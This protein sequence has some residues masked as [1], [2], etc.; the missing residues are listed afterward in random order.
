MGTVRFG[1]GIYTCESL[2]TVLE[3]ARLAESLGYDSLWLLDSQ[4]V[5]RECYATMASCALHTSR[6]TIGSGVTN[7]YTRHV[8]VTASAHLTLN[9]LA[10]G[11]IAVGIGRGDSAVLGLGAGVPSFGSY[12]EYVHAL[13]RLL[14]GEQIDVNG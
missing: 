6:I 1:V 2:S 9:E 11:R 8:T 13:R 7:P 5:G 12:A 3:H 14:A 4:L 10:P